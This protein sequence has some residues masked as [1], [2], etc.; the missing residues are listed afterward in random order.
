MFYQDELVVQTYVPGVADWLVADEPL[1]LGVGQVGGDDV[2]R[3]LADV[4]VEGA[5]VHHHGALQLVGRGVGVP[6]DEDRD[7]VEDASLP[8]GGGLLHLVGVE[9]LLE[10]LL[11]GVHV[12]APFLEA[13]EV[14]LPLPHYRPPSRH[15]AMS[16]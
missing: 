12:A 1:H 4:V 5:A 14:A 2:R 6:V 7:A 3:P 8:L 16:L 13:V 9:L 10:L 11:L 15:G